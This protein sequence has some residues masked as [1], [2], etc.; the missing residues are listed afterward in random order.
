[1]KIIVNTRLLLKNRLEGIGWFTCETLKRI[2]KAH[3]EHS[4]VF[5]FDRPFHSDFIFADNVE[6]LIVG[7]ATRHPLLWYTWFEHIVPKVLKKTNADLFFSPDGYLSLRTNIPQVPVIHDI[8]FIHRPNDLPWMSRYYYNRYFPKFAEKASRIATVSNYSANDIATTFGVD[9]SRIDVV[10]N[11]INSIFKPLGDAKKAAVRKKYSGGVPYF[12]YVGAIHP[13][14]NVAG[15]LKAYEHFRNQYQEEVRL[16]IA[17][18]AMFG[19]KEVKNIYREMEYRN[20][21]LF[22]GRVPSIELGKL[23]GASEALAFFPFF[24]GFGIP[25][26]EAMAAGVPVVCSNTTSLP[27]VGG[28]AAR[29][30]NP[31]SIE[32]MAET[33]FQVYTDKRLKQEMVAKGLKQSALFSWDKS[34]E[35]LWDAI[36]KS[37][38][39]A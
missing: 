22:V 11:G 10:Y 18:G 4:F 19:N 13:R 3:P 35:L 16:I 21:V 31:E 5:L 17:G 28:D 6:P 33:L 9:R 20:D 39:K 12:F 26:I 2:V 34:A 25:V 30:V 37:L 8:N 38:E 36:E 1:M 15:L 29:Y 7:P 32:E 23:L 14:K 27:E 24:E